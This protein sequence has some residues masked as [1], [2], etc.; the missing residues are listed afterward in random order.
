MKKL[1]F[2]ALLLI[3]I[4]SCKSSEVSFVNP[5]LFG[6]WVWISTD[7]GIGNHIH[8][9]PESTGFT[10]E[11]R[12]NKDSEYSL[13]KSKLRIGTGS[14]HITEKRSLLQNKL[15]AFITLDENANDS[16][17]IISSGMLILEKKDTLIISQDV[18]DGVGSTFARLK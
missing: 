17:N 5:E 13:Y 11:L 18:Y 14:Y 2:A 8:N 12:L 6:T 7:G 4:F 16:S 1:F 3:I 15:A 9:T 10:I